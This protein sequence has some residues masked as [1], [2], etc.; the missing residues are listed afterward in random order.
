MTNEIRERESVNCRI[1]RFDRS[2]GTREEVSSES[3]IRHPPREPSDCVCSTKR[4]AAASSSGCGKF[5]FLARS[6]GKNSR[7]LGLTLCVNALKHRTLFEN[8]APLLCTIQQILRL[9]QAMRMIPGCADLQKKGG[10]RGEAI[11]YTCKA[12][13]RI[14]QLSGGQKGGIIGVSACV[15]T[16]CCYAREQETKRHYIS[17]SGPV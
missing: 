1:S 12:K 10:W 14:R 6:N 13:V 9:G 4:S 16:S 3:D 7:I 5:S 8:L 17:V 15:Y 2:A 11:K